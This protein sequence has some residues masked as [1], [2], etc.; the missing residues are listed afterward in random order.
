LFAK[1]SAGHIPT[2]VSIQ[3]NLKGTKSPYWFFDVEEI[4]MQMTTLGFKL[5]YKSSLD[6]VYDQ[7]NFEEKYR[8]GKACNLLFS[9]SL[10]PS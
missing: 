10:R 8:L 7:D 4:I 9:R 3:S 6:R 1:L 2:Y 5:I